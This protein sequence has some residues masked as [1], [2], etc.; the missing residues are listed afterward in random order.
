MDKEFLIGICHYYN[1]EEE[2]PF[3]DKTKTMLWNIEREWVNEVLSLGGESTLVLDE[4]Q[5]TFMST[6]L[7]GKLSPTMPLNY[8]AFLYYRLNDSM[9]TKDAFVELFESYYKE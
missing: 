2:S 4:A 5:A 6:D 3:D 7:L 1:G 9:I 8:K